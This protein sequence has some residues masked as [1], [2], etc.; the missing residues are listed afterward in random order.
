MAREQIIWEEDF[1]WY[2][3]YRKG[4]YRL[5]T[6]TGEVGTC[7]KDK[8]VRMSTHII[9]DKNNMLV[10]TRPKTKNIYEPQKK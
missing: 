7:S 1:C 6:R 4:I 8:K 2:P 10:F 3:S 9:Q 5:N